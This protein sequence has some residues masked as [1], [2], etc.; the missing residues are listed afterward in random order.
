MNLTG[1]KK[2]NLLDRILIVLAVLYAFYS[3][4][5]YFAWRTFNNGIFGYLI[6]SIPYRTIFGVLFICAFFVRSKGKIKCDKK[7]RYLSFGVLI[8][9]VFC[10][11]LAGGIDNTHTF[12]MAWIP[13]LTVFCFIFLPKELKRKA[14]NI[15][16]CVFAFTLILPIIFYALE[17]TG[18][19]MSYSILEPQEEIK[20]IRG[21]FYRHYLGA[22]QRDHLYDLLAQ[23]K[24]CGIYDESGKLG[25]LAALFLIGE[26]FKLKKNW[27]AIIALIGG[28]L[29]FSLA[30]YL[31]VAI[32]YIVM[33][34]VNRKFKNI[35]AITLV[36]AAYFTFVNIPIQDGVLKNLQTRIMI[37]ESGLAGDNRVNDS[38]NALID[39]FNQ[40]G[41]L[42]TYAFGYGDGAIAQVQSQNNIDGSS[43]KS[44]I[45]NFGYVGFASIVLWL[46]L[47][48]YLYSRDLKFNVNKAQV[49]AIVI[50]YIIN[51]YQRPTSFYLGYMMIMIGAIEMIRQEAGGSM[52][53]K[54]LEQRFL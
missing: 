47:Y 11:A 54:R 19:G 3:L 18:H 6:G 20:V 49:W 4:E 7:T 48:G 2:L 8:S 43:Y 27:K 45:Y 42:Y 40:N 26:R 34:V 31:L 52:N 38:F 41:T 51:L 32:Y 10:V 30:F 12:S 17:L 24:M 35:I 22:V 53:D 37:T 21:F 44:F 16:F 39:D 28:V 5:P 15:Y 13:Y 23:Y 33:C 14:Y 25:T 36:I 29:S 46:L 9:S 50:A 1:E